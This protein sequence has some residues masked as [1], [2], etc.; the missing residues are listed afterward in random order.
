M[1]GSWATALALQTLDLSNN[2]L[3]GPLPDAWGAPNGFRSLQRLQVPPAF[4]GAPCSAR[5]GNDGCP[6]GAVW[7]SVRGPAPNI[8]SMLWDSAEAANCTRQR[9]TFK[10][11]SNAVSTGRAASARPKSAPWHCIVH[12]GLS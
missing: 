6:R 5:H 11:A 1:E 10:D 12:L 3:S 9:T 8:V 7:V 4:T 2:E